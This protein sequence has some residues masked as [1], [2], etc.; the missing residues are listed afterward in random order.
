MKTKILLMT[1]LLI[2]S[3]ITV[4]GKVQDKDKKAIKAEK[5]LQLQKQIEEIINSRQFIFIG[6]RAL[7]MWGTSITL[8]PNSNYF[9]FDPANIES[10]MPFFGDA[11]SVNY[12]VDPG[13]KFEGKPGEFEI[14]QLQKGKGYDI[15][16]KVSIPSDTYDIFM[17]V[18][19]DGTANLTISS[20]KR[21]SISY[22]GS[23]SIP[24]IPVQKE[25]G[26]VNAENT[27]NVIPL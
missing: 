27:K 24:E 15:R 3:L 17:H 8:T 25:K 11:Y 1:T 9:K 20:F 2:F 13:V 22:M 4:Y 6:E 16:V 5:R 10:Y 12:N 18:S 14:K 7:P 19:L 21:S 26:A 23:L